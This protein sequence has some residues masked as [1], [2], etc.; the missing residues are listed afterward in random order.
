MAYFKDDIP[1]FQN[2]FHHSSENFLL[3]FKNKHFN[4]LLDSSFK[5][6]EFAA[7]LELKIPV[8]RTSLIDQ[9]F[10]SGEWSQQK[11]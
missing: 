3:N 10:P 9:V 11:I 4:S 2:K 8:N 1:S 7:S 6:S 5:F